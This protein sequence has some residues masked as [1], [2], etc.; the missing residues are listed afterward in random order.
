MRTPLGKKQG[1]SGSTEESCK[2]RETTFGGSVEKYRLTELTLKPTECILHERLEWCDLFFKGVGAPTGQA[3][4]AR[5][6]NVQPQN[7][8][9][10]SLIEELVI[11]SIF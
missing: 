4:F 6:R 11:F 1:K 9:K 8:L 7:Q 2:H 10:R 3:K 5:A